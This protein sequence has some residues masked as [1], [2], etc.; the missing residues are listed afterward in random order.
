MS[1]TAP[2]CLRCGS[3]MEQG[4]VADKGDYNALD[5]QRW[6]EGA[7]E[8]SFWTGIKTKNRE[9]LVVSTFRCERCGYL[10]SY[11]TTPPS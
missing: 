8:R 7:P 3:A 6:I 4:F 1:S 11:A 5:L 2:S 10:E 9:V